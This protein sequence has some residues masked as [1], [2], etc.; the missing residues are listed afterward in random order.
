M[1]WED[2]SGSTE[3]C[4]EVLEIK[5]GKVIISCSLPLNAQNTELVLGHTTSGQRTGRGNIR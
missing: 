3:P 1:S 5:S 2:L 4:R